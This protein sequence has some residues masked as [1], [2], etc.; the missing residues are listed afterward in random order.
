MDYSDHNGVS[1]VIDNADSEEGDSEQ[2]E[3]VHYTPRRKMFYYP[4]QS[5]FITPVSYT[6][7]TLPTNR[8]V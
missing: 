1:V 6:H 7:L 3:N 5:R 8:E 4:Y 2:E